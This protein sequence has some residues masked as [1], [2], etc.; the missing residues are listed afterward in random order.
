M[1]GSVSGCPKVF[2][3]RPRSLAHS[4]T[5][6]LDL[7][8]RSLVCVDCTQEADCPSGTYCDDS[9]NSCIDGCNEDIDCSGNHP[10]CRQA[11]HQCVQCTNNDPLP[12]QCS[13]TPGTVCELVD[14]ARINECVECSP[15]IPTSC[16]GDRVCNPESGMF[17]QHLPCP[18][19]LARL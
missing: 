8:A 4:L 5:R 12:A 15:S 16:P 3:I 11:D 19:P 14:A 13:D 17:S 10:Y 6:S 18:P 1:T 2:A 7:C 9:T